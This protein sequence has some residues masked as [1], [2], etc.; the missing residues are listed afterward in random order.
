M[1]R[2]LAVQSELAGE[3]RKLKRGLAAKFGQYD[4]PFRI[5]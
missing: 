4:E 2:A 3:L 5:V 1:R